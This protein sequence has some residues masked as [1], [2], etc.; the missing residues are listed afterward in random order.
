VTDRQD[1]GWVVRLRHQI[2]TTAGAQHKSLRASPFAPKSRA[3]VV[4]ML[5]NP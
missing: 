1:L 4:A 2:A 3:L 5:P